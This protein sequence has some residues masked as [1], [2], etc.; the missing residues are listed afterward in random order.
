MNGSDDETHQQDSEVI[1]YAV[2]DEDEGGP[3]G[4]EDLDA[5]LRMDS[6][7]EPRLLEP[8]AA[9]DRADTFEELAGEWFAVGP[10]EDDGPS[11]LVLSEAH[12]RLRSLDGAEREIIE[13]RFGFGGEEPMS[14]REI[15]DH[16]GLEEKRVADLIRRALKRM[17]GR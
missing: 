1:G 4:L 15:A 10:D 11:D 9:D 6:E 14:V 16:F 13:L 3:L 17:R 7:V 2:D 12:E 5:L 8:D